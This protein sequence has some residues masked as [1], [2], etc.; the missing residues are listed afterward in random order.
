MYK[1]QVLQTNLDEF[2]RCEE[3][4]QMTDHGKSLSPTQ[5]TDAAIKESVYNA[6]W[7]DNVLRALEYYEIDVHVKNGVVYLYGHIVG[8]SSQSRIRNAIQGIPG[9]V[10][11]K[12]NLVLDDMLTREVARAL[13]DLEHTFN[14][15][16]FT[17]VS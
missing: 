15:K 13:G 11:I 12:N 3:R 1:E 2:S 5:K 14:C 17:G 4:R 7:N 10:E 16:F 9:I 6:L 8:S